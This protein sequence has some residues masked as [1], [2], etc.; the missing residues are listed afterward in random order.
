MTPD[1]IIMGF[2]LLILLGGQAY[3]LYK[4]DKEY[5]ETLAEYLKELDK[6]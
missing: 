1:L 3:K 5:N 2:C 4:A 6:D